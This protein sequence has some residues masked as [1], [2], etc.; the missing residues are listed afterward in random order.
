LI[1]KEAR[2]I[3]AELL[4]K[5][6]SQEIT[7]WQLEDRWPKSEADPA[8]NCILRW[9]WTCYNDDT[10]SF[11]GELVS[12]EVQTLARCVEFLS[13]DLAFQTKIVS[14]KEAKELV[15]KWGVEWRADC[16]CPSDAATWPFFEEK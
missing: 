10:E 4:A 14:Q 12:S 2:Q 16:T 13:T 6:R 15:K 9:V 5:Y 8:I 3:A 7:N 11:V 1:D